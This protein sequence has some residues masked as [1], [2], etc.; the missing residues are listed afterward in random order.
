MSKR[1]CRKESALETRVTLKD[2][3]K[4]TNVSVSTVSDI[5]NSRPISYSEPVKTRVFEAARELGYRPNAIARGLRTKKTNTIGLAIPHMSYSYFDDIAV[6]LER[7]AKMRQNHVI[8]VFTTDDQ[9]G[10]AEFDELEMLRAKQVDG[11]II[12]PFG[13]TEYSVSTYSRLVKT[14][15]PIV[16][17]DQELESVDASFV[18]TDDVAGARVATEY[19][20][21][22]GHRRIAHLSA[23][24]QTVTGRRRLQGY[25]AA[26]EES[27]I[28]FDPSLVF[29]RAFEGSDNVLAVNGL[30]ECAEL[31][32]AVFCANDLK[33]AELYK[34]CWERSL[35]IPE[36]ISVIGFCGLPLSQYLTPPLTTMLQPTDALAKAAVQILF[37]DMR[38]K[39]KS[40]R[41]CVYLKAELMERHSVRRL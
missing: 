24:H 41:R 32:T 8:T 6:A 16:I 3:S 11:M 19:L 15:M 35:S 12:T 34:G 39:G 7:Y 31:P 37:E 17:I 10:E 26:L 23:H 2:I 28:G 4:L 14:G 40:P 1:E 27:G 33:A 30:L 22:K 20:I 18:G 9:A 13:D 5:L 36:D 29:G 25:R 38:A 21:E